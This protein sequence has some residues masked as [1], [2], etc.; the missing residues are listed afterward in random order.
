MQVEIVYGAQRAWVTEVGGGLR[1][2]DVDGRRVVD[3]YAVTEMASAGRGQLLVPWPNRVGDGRYRFQGAECQ[4]PLTEPS[5]HNAIHGLARW[6]NWVLHQPGPNLVEARFILHPQPGYPYS[7]RLEVEYRLDEAGL[8][9]HVAATNVGDRP[10]PYGAGQ[11]PYVTVGTDLV[12]DALLR[13]PAKAVVP[14]DER[15][16]PTGGPV[17]IAGTELDFRRP[18]MIGPLILDTCYAD[19]QHDANGVTAVVLAPSGRRQLRDGLG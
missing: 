5:N 18:R 9:V 10:A 8:R 4:L 11:H 2:Y 1:S 15:G 19:L 17:A 16:L 7:L 14:T 3:G 12:D 6:S 13:V